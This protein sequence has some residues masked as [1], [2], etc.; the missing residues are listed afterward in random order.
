MVQITHNPLLS[1]HLQNDELTSNSC[2]YIVFK[3]KILNK[4]VSLMLQNL[5]KPM[6]I[7]CK[8]FDMFLTIINISNFLITQSQMNDDFTKNLQQ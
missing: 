3:P 1:L 5:N 6:A 8:A 2:T 7:P 4:N